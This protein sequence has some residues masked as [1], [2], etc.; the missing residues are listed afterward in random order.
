VILNESTY[1]DSDELTQFIGNY[2]AEGW[3]VMDI[4]AY[5]YSPGFMM[6][7]LLRKGEDI[8][9]VT[10]DVE[11]TYPA[12]TPAVPS[13]SMFERKLWEMSGIVPEGH[14]DLSP[15]IYWRKG[16]GYPLQKESYMTYGETRIPIPKNRLAG[17]GVFEI[18]VGP[19]HAGVIEP[20]HFRFSTAGEPILELKVHLGYKHKGIEKLMEGSVD[21]N[22]SHLAERISGDNAVAHSLA[23]AHAM[24]GLTDIPERAR[25]IRVI[26]AELERIHNHL[27]V[28]AGMCTD[29]A[30]SVAAAFGQEA[31]EILLRTNQEVFGSRLLM[32]SVVPGGVRRDLTPEKIKKL[33][34]AVMKARFAATELDGYMKKSPSETDRLETTGI[35]SE[36]YARKLGTVGVIA[37]ASGIGSDVRKEVPYDDYGNL[38]MNIITER[39]GDCLARST[40]RAGE[41]GESVSLIL[42]CLSKIET[43]DVYVQPEIPMGM[44]CGIVESPRGELL[45]SAEIIDNEIWRY[46]IRD[47]SFVNWPALEVSVLKDIVPDFPLINKSFGLSYSGNDV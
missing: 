29:T 45:H 33:E 5:D 47:P 35:L 11:N 18:P 23:H 7:F 19:V 6:N 28:L 14:E 2:H 40:V 4:F 16:D 34:N 22:L 10:S 42:Q 25:V 31:R 46:S 15:V 43:G 9:R 20:G 1:C 12:V 36:K 24:E 38:S 37:R 30:F 26:L 41:I 44:A 32:G 3:R 39:D 17:P 27:E 13:A 21:R 8:L